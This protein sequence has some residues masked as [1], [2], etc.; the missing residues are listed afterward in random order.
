MTLKEAAQIHAIEKE[1][2]DAGCD[3]ITGARWMRMR[4]LKIINEVS[5]HCIELQKSDDISIETL[6]VIDQFCN[7]IYEQLKEIE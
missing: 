1:C 6:T 2:A 4:M 7:K 3:F 5:T